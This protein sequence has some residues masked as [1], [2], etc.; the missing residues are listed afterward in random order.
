MAKSF[1]ANTCAAL[2]QAQC[3]ATT[4]GSFNLTGSIIVI[5]VELVLMLFWL[6]SVYVKSFHGEKIHAQY[7][8]WPTWCGL[9]KGGLISKEEKLPKIRVQDNLLFFRVVYGFT[10]IFWI[11]FALIARYAVNAATFAHYDDQMLMLNFVPYLVFEFWALFVALRLVKHET[12]SGNHHIL[13]M[14]HNNMHIDNF[15]L[16]ITLNPIY[17]LSFHSTHFYP[18][19]SSA[20]CH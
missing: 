10:I 12:V 3:L 19:S 15:I 4:I 6:S 2:S 14:T 11:L 9:L 7:Y 13:C 17:I 1:S 16:T 5:F 8:R 18:F 20:D